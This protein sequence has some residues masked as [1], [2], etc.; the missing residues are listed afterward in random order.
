MVSSVQIQDADPANLVVGYRRSGS[1][2]RQTFGVCTPDVARSHASTPDS[3]HPTIH[4]G[5]EIRRSF[6]KKLWLPVRHRNVDKRRLTSPWTLDKP[7]SV[8]SLYYQIALAPYPSK[9]GTMSQHEKA[10]AAISEDVM[11]PGNTTT[12]GNEEMGLKQID[13]LHDD[14]AVKVL[15]AYHGDQSWTPAEE[16]KLRRKID[17]KLLPV[18]CGTYCLLYYDKAM[19]GQAVTTT[20]TSCLCLVLTYGVRHSLVSER[21][22]TSPRAIVIHSLRRY[23]TLDS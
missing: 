23:S 12:M 13:T 8:S 18:L 19:L 22:L 15:A 5:E 14:E 21:I 17:W 6:C 4:N 2:P 3:T 16:Q 10:D 7:A 9:P 20:L 11:T 1:Y